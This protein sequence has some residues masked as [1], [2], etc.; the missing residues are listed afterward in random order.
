MLKEI[1]KP[2]HELHASAIKIGE[3]Y[4]PVDL[5][6]G[7]FLRQSKT[8]H[9]T[10]AHQVKDVFV[11]LSI[12]EVKAQMD[13]TQCKFGKWYYGPEV[14]ERKAKDPEFAALL[15]PIEEVHRKLHESA[16]QVDQYLKED[17]RDEGSGLLHEEH[18]GSGLS[19]IGLDR[20]GARVERR[21]SAA[22]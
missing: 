8:D 17:R 6:L 3:L 16:K 20:Q 18:K 19:G 1:E 14:A 22:V 21:Q 15:A 10:W 4:R 13:P 12:T 7:N 5:E 11:D 2:H 9:L